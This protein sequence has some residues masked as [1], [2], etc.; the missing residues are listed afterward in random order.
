MNVIATQGLTKKFGDLVAVGGPLGG[1]HSRICELSDEFRQALLDDGRT[2]RLALFGGTVADYWGGRGAVNAGTGL[3]QVHADFLKR[4]TRDYS[5]PGYAWSEAVRRAED[6][7]WVALL[8]PDA[9]PEPHR[10]H[11][12]VSQGSDRLVGRTVREVDECHDRR[13]EAQP[14]HDGTGVAPQ[15]QTEPSRCGSSLDAG[16]IRRIRTHQDHG[17]ASRD[18]VG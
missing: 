2:R 7:H 9:F 5:I 11:V 15:Q 4:R 10:S 13:Y 18:T 16:T 12:F 3:V 6:A 8:N 1:R 17:R 14:L